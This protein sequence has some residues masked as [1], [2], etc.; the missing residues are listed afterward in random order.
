MKFRSLLLFPV[1][2]AL[3]AGCDRSAVAPSSETAA[4]SRLSNVA[5]IIAVSKLRAEAQEA[6]VRELY[7]ASGW[8]AM[9]SP[10]AA[11]ALTSAVEKRARH[12]LDRLIFLPA[13]SKLSAAAREIALTGAAL[14]FASTLA[15]GAT[16]PTKLHT[17]YTHPRPK[18]D[19]ASGLV[20]AVKAGRLPAWLDSLAPG[21]PEYAALAKAY[22]QQRQAASQE[23]G[24]DIAGG[25][26]IQPGDEDP[27]I[28][29]II[30][31][32]Q[33]N[34]Y[35]PSSKQAGPPPGAGATIYNPDM[36]AGVKAFQ[37]DYGI[38]DDGVI[39][40]DTLA[41]L[42][43][44]PGDRARSLAVALER[45]R[46][47]TRNPPPTRIDVNA[48]AAELSYYREGKLVD[49]R[50]VVVGRPG[51]ETP[52]IA[53]SMHRLV[54]NPTWTVPRSIQKTEMAGKSSAYFRRNH[55]SW[56]DGWIVQRSGPKNSL[57]LVKFDLANDLAI[58]LHDTPAKAL[59]GRHQRQLSHGC[60][61]V[62][63]APGFAR[64]LAEQQ[65]ITNQWS[66]AATSGKMTFVDLP[67]A[68]PVR[69]LYRTAY[70]NLAGQVT[71]RTDPY[72]WNDAVAEA[73]G[74]EKDASK[75]FI[76]GVRD[77]GP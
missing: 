50:N 6:P 17:V 63:D 40:A 47:L 51:D 57:G 68:I 65:G 15:R 14:E 54:A 33:E 70:A 27:R 8:T 1:V 69:L 13:L 9:W 58:Y 24:G 72:G 4:Q 2:L 39:G 59:F 34:Q 49:R 60:V 12:G 30:I 75:K 20:T 76:S 42:N 18:P 64:M 71:F 19:L 53:T 52:Q 3:V 5:P 55:L 35:L 23:T 32:L 36:V 29:Q 74:F 48:A 11:E 67:E 43:V 56:Q 26:L 41:I 38:S 16:D 37:R 73:L 44:R 31:A 21:N 25:D 66:S 77:I 62:S 45:L 7:E 28:P 10:R 22:L 61:R 46:W